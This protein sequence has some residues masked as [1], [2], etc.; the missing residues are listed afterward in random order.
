LIG[1]CFKITGGRALATAAC[2]V[3]VV[4]AGCK[5]SGSGT[6][7]AA[8]TA[9]CTGNASCGPGT[10]CS[11]TPGLCG[12]GAKPGVC[13]PRPPSCP[14]GDYAPAC[15]CD[16][17]IYDD[18]CAAHAAGVD[19]DVTGACT[20]VIPDWVACGARFCDARTSYCEIHV[21]AA[22]E[23]PPAYSCR[24]MPEA[25]RPPA[26]DGGAAGDAGGARDGG[27]TPSCGCFP[28]GTPCLSSCGLLATGGRPGFQLT[29]HPAPQP[30]PK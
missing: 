16:G 20:A 10:Y 25:C 26:D 17:K 1:H 6:Q 2:L 11:F 14:G 18:Q 19:L 3:F 9:G 27:A 24:P 28:E 5:R 30:R 7:S 8:L 12:R 21:G 4:A 13:K 29:C 15:G 23:V 22:P